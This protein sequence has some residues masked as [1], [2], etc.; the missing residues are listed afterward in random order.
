MK[1]YFPKLPSYNRFIELI[2]KVI[3]QLTL[4]MQSKAAKAE[5]IFYVDSTSLPACNLGRSKRYKTF[6]EPEFEV[7]KIKHSA[8]F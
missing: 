5:G 4:F 3:L 2:P 7:L 8:I 6:C 1:K